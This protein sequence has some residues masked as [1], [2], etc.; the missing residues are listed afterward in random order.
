MARGIH[1]QLD[2]AGTRRDGHTIR[3][4]TTSV[5]EERSRCMRQEFEVLALGLERNDSLCAVHERVGTEIPF[6]CANVD[7]S[8]MPKVRP[9]A[10]IDEDIPNDVAVGL[11]VCIGEEEVPLL[12]SKSVCTQPARA[13]PE[14][15]ANELQLRG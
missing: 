9:V 13:G 1:P 2:L 6:V 11:V 12:E 4:P 3:V 5:F 7:D 10:A 15:V 8:R 14:P